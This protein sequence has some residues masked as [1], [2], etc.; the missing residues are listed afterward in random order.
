MY[1]WPIYYCPDIIAGRVLTVSRRLALFMSFMILFVICVGRT[2]LSHSG[3]RGGGFA[4]AACAGTG[5]ERD[6]MGPGVGAPLPAGFGG[7]DDAGGCVR[8]IDILSILC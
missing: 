3:H 5:L 4:S 2:S 6:G 1:T 8:Y 7:D